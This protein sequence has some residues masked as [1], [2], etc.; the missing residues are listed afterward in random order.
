M[1]TVIYLENINVIG[2]CEQWIYEIAKKYSDDYDIELLYKTGESKQ[3]ERLK[4]LIRCTKYKNEEINC[5]TFITAYSHG[6][7]EKSNA[8]ENIVTIH[9]NYEY[10]KI[11]IKIHPKTTKIYAVSNIA[12]KGFENTHKEQLEAMGL[13]V[14]VLYNPYT[15]EQSKRVLRLISATRLTWQK[16]LQEM[17]MIANKLNKKGYLFIWH[18]FTNDAVGYIDNF[19]KMKTTLDIEPYIRDADYLIQVSE[20]EGYAY[21]IVQ[22]LALGTPVVCR[23]I[24]IR[25]E[26]GVEHK[27]NGLV[28]N[29]DMSNIDEVVDL[30]YT[31][32]L[33]G[34]KY[35]VKESDKMWKKV[36]GCPSTSNYK[37]ELK[38]KYKVE[39]LP[40]FEERN[41][42]DSDVQ[43]SRTTGEQWEV[44]KER[45]DVLLGDNTYGVP[46]VK[47]IESIREE[48]KE[49]VKE[50]IKKPT[51]KK[52][53]KK[54]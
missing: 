14:E 46:F 21:S 23:D 39:A 11:K 54:K 6:I 48:E 1:K 10:E 19:I 36:L 33:K 34:F 53:T 42:K 41:I 32:D 27:E 16:G 26:I 7:M 9:A 45:L 5:D 31:S 38:M 47:L 8:K 12:K 3:L 35:E 40:I 25:E 50:T 49:E 43:R 20:S 2:G 44:G 51:T 52:Q 15:P 4:K 37:E 13:K 17:Q 28:L 18:V 30:M 22:A 29:M 24:L